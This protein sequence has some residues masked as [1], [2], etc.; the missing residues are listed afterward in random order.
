MVEQPNPNPS[1]IQIQ[2]YLGGI[3]YPVGK[4]EVIA[5]A[6][7]AGADEGVLRMLDLLPD[8]Q[9]E[10]PIDVSREATEGEAAEGAAERNG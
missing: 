4:N 5:A 6:R 10:A 2:R 8:R 1:A 3:D 7:D 9:Y